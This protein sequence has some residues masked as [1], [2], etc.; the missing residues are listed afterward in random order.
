MKLRVDQ[1]VGTAQVEGQGHAVTFD[2]ETGLR[3]TPIV[4]SARGESERWNGIE[5]SSSTSKRRSEMAIGPTPLGFGSG[6]CAPMLSRGLPWSQTRR[7][8]PRHQ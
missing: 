4:A 3:R 1:Q 8:S 5:E 2:F 6:H 7:A